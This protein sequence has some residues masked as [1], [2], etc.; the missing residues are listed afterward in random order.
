MTTFL[1]QRYPVRSE[2]DA[3]EAAF[4]GTLWPGLLRSARM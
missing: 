3:Q 1:A 2:V 4:L